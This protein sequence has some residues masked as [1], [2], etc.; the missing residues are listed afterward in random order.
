MC[1]C[2]TVARAA[3]LRVVSTTSMA[4]GDAA[5]RPPSGSSLDRVLALIEVMVAFVLV[6]VTFR[7]IKH[8]TVVGQW[9]P[10]RNF[11]PGVVMIAFTITALLLCGRRFE[12]YGL[13]VKRWSEHLSLGLVCSVLIL[14]VAAFALALT[15]FHFDASK[16]PAPHASQFWRIIGLTVIAVPGFLAV[17]VVLWTRARSIRRM[18]ALATVPA[19]FVLLAVP[20]I[21]MKWHHQPAALLTVL[22][23]FLGAGFGEE[24]FY[25]G[26]IQSRVDEAFGLPFRVPGCELGLGLLVSSLLF[27]LVHA[28]DTVDYFAGHFEFGWGYGVQNFFEGLFFRCVRAKTGSVLPG[29]VMHGFGDAFARISNLLR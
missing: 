7:A 26:Y 4:A 3:E 13:S 28:L 27:G 17:L 24:I 10:G 19:M 8:F 21:V 2:G 16:P 15:R 12:V 5:K 23:L 20:V 14:A 25:R 22:W 18:P 6:H 11:T 29:A 9:N 1:I